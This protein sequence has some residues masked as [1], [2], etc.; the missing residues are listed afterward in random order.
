[1]ALV[2][3]REAWPHELHMLLDHYNPMVNMPRT[4]RSAGQ[5][6]CAVGSPFMHHSVH[7]FWI[8]DI[9]RVQ[10]WCSVPNWRGR[11]S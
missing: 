5:D 1:M 4:A 6:G 11:R 2:P 8:M 9:D 10:Q 3:K 7:A